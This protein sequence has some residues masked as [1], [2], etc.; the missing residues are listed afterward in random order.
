MVSNS[1]MRYIV[2]LFGL[3]TAST[4]SYGGGLLGE[5]IDSVSQEVIDVGRAVDRAHKEIKLAVPDYRAL[6][7]IAKTS[8]TK[9]L[10][11]DEQHRGREHAATIEESVRQAEQ[12]LRKIDVKL[13]ELRVLG[14][15]IEAE[16]N[17][18]AREKD[19]IAKEKQEVERREQLFSIGFYA[20]LATTIIAVLALLLRLP[21]A[22]LER[23][24]K[25]LEIAQME[26]E[27]AKLRA[28]VI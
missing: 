5:A 16:K 13:E 22:R 20:S 2:L 14:S 6:E 27:L 21:T 11:Q 9:Q 7:Q 10:I 24:L 8:E 1:R 25:Q 18:L 4:T 15:E 12:K 23:H 17:A 19:E 3:I 26:F 28:E